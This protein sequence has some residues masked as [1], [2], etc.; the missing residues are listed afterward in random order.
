MLICSVGHGIVLHGIVWYC[1]VLYGNAVWYLH[2][3]L[4]YCI[5]L[6]Y[7]ACYFWTCIEW[8]YLVLYGII[9][10]CNVLH[11]IVWYNIGC[12]VLHGIVGYCNVLHHVAIYQ[13]VLQS[14]IWYYTVL[15]VI[16]WYCIGLY[17]V[18][19]Y[20][21]WHFRWGTILYGIV[22]VLYSVSW[23]CFVWFVLYDIA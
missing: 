9:Q 2:N 5:V 13:M 12:T 23:Q 19:F 4:W 16:I 11:G 15:H 18:A 1:T 17:G 21:V 7:I 22:L 6:Y 3:I 8:Y 20:V 10:Y 14:N